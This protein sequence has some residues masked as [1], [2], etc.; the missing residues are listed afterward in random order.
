[1]F[2]CVALIVLDYNNNDNLRLSQFLHL[3]FNSYIV[4]KINN[5]TY[6]III[7]IETNVPLKETIM[8]EL[9]KN[10]F[11]NK[12]EIDCL[13]IGE[14]HF[15]TDTDICNGYLNKHYYDAVYGE[16][17]FEEYNWKNTDYIPI[18][19]TS[20]K[21]YE[22]IHYI[23]DIRTYKDYIGLLNYI[24]NTDFFKSDTSQFAV[25]ITD[26]FNRQGVPEEHNDSNVFFKQSIIEENKICSSKKKNRKV[27]I[28]E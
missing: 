8:K 22:D 15:D 25:S 11:T 16:F 4:N 12:N 21:K 20:F 7:K 17:N 2:A 14:F 27:F 5:C 3:P 18:L 10:V 26:L 9:T 1:M 6:E 24:K 23:G 13:I 19:N 28:F